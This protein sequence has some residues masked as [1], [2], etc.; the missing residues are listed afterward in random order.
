M[1]SV[2]QPRKQLEDGPSADDAKVIVDMQVLGD[3]SDE[4]VEI[5]PEVSAALAFSSPLTPA[6]NFS[7]A[8]V[9]PEPGKLNLV[10]GDPN[11]TLELS[12]I[13]DEEDEKV[14]YPNRP[15]AHDSV[16]IT[17]VR[18]PRIGRFIILTLL[19]AI[20]GVGLFIAWKNNFQPIIWENPKIAAQIAFTGHDPRPAPAKPLPPAPKPTAPI[21]SLEVVDVTVE[22]L[23]GG[24]ALLTG[25]ISNPT[26]GVHHAVTIEAQLRQGNL[27]LHRRVI[28]CCTTFDEAE[29]AKVAADPGHP[30]FA[31]FLPELADIKI[32]PGGRR[33]FN[34]VFLKEGSTALGELTPYAEIKHSEA[35]RSP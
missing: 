19:L 25:Q 13:T 2:D 26:E 10:E 24:H 23:P 8:P 15:N 35:T 6:V 34:V 30:H 33:L 27:P 14:H 16:D 18:Q 12:A 17:V 11:Q 29:A 4:Q 31:T 21:G 5:D 3:H 1:S 20:I 22:P 28:P 9:L 7:A 32:P